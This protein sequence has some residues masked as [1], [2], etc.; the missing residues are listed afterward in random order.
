MALVTAMSA[1][2]IMSFV[3]PPSDSSSVA[4]SALSHS[5]SAGVNFS[6]TSAT[7][8]CAVSRCMKSCFTVF[9]GFNLFCACRSCAWNLLISA[10]EASRAVGVS[11]FRTEMFFW[12]RKTRVALIESCATFTAVS[13]SSTARFASGKSSPAAWIISEVMIALSTKS[14]AVLDRSWHSGSISW[15]AFWSLASAALVFPSCSALTLEARI[16]PSSPAT[17]C[18]ADLRAVPSCANCRAASPLAVLCSSVTLFRASARD[19]TC[20][21]NRPSATFSPSAEA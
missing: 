6:M 17:C 12:F 19:S 4:S 3:E 9:S 8:L 15:K 10:M 5:I 7:H 13:V 11:N 14:S 20:G 16:L 2:T 18:W 1:C 21:A